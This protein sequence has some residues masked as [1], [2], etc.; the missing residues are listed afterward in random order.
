M[1]ILFVGDVVGRS[2]R[3][4]VREMLPGIQEAN[5]VDL[6]IV[7][8]ENAAGG[9]GITKEVAREIRSYGVDVM[10]TGNHVWDK[11]EAMEYLNQEPRLLRPGNYPRG[12][13]GSGAYLGETAAGIPVAVLNIQGRVF[14]PLTDCP[15]QTVQR[16]MQRLRR[17]NAVIIVD[18]HAEA[19]SEKQ[20][21]GWFLDG[22]VA[23]VVGTHTHVPTA[24]ARV[25]PK[26]TA[27]VSDVG[28][29]GPFDSIIGM[30]V[31]NSMKRFLTGLPSR[32][33]TA[34]DYPRLCSVLIDVDESKGLARSIRRMDLDG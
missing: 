6:T 11:A 15:F 34:S 14:M 21:M 10:T 22:Q 12:A 4:L 3:R 26:G 25:L 1:K 7:N 9:F 30:K 24:D 19:T 31:E 32:F 17:D 27:Y 16:E 2:G 23:A 5:R 29:T 13:P 8:V 28:M 33:E 18:F 20:A